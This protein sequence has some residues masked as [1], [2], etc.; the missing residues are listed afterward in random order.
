MVSRQTLKVLDRMY[1]VGVGII[2]HDMRY[3]CA[4]YLASVV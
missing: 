3:Q 2:I 1:I 4:A